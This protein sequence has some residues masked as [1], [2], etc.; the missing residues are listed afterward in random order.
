MLSNVCFGIQ[1]WDEVVTY[2]SHLI[3]HLP[4]AALKS[5]TLLEVWFD[6]F[7]DDYDSL[8]VF[9]STTLPREGI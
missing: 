1:L 5:K 7:V 2:G 9:I 3:N 6:K 8:R 4:S